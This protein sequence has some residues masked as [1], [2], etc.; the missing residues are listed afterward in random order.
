MSPNKQGKDLIASH[1]SD[2]VTEVNV[3]IGH[4]G[5]SDILSFLADLSAPRYQ[6]QAACPLPRQPQIAEDK[7]QTLYPLNTQGAQMPGR[8][9]QLHLDGHVHNRVLNLT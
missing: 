9:G 8:L 5:Y 3:P 1:R 4:A 2:S 6:I 7:P